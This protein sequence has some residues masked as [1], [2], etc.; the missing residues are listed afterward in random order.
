[1]NAPTVEDLLEYEYSESLGQDVTVF[2][3]IKGFHQLDIVKKII[4]RKGY[5]GYG[6][7]AAQNVKERRY[8]NGCILATKL[9]RGIFNDDLLSTADRIDCLEPFDIAIFDKSFAY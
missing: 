8:S 3:V 9:D 5:R 2:L 1:M 4:K 6:L 7:T